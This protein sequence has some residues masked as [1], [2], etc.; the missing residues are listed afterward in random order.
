MKLYKLLSIMAFGGMTFAFSSC[1]NADKSFPDYEGGTSVYFAYQYPVRTIVL[2]N[3]DIVDNSLDRQHKCAI[4]STMGG[5]YGGRNITIDIAV[6]NTLCDNLFFEDGTPVLPMPS[7][8]YSL[9]GDKIDYKGEHWGN[10]E[11]QLTDAFFA[12]EKALERNYVIPVV[13]KG[14][15]GAD[16]IL[17]GTPLI[18]GDKPVRTNSDYWSVAPM[19]YVL[20]CVKYMNPWHASYLRRGIDKI[21]ENGTVTTAVRHAQSVE[22]DEVC[23]ITTRSLKSSVFPVSMNTADGTTVNCDLLLTFNDKDECTITS[24]TTGISATGSGKFVEDGEKK[25]WGNKDRDAIYLEY[26]VDFG[27]KQIATKDTLVLQ[28]RGTNKLE[29]FSPK[30]VAN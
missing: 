15:T 30:Y 20:Y 1:E 29:V 11:V 6:D 25:S 14:Q 12:D 16:R 3:D 23:G 2:G 4:Y 28:T 7:T 22:K 18:E 5:A 24:A 26:N 13:M 19:D 8:H 21:T 27:T 10:V 17:A 9:A